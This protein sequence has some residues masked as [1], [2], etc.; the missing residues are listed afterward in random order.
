MNYKIEYDNVYDEL[1][2]RGYIDAATHEDEIKEMLATK[3]VP[4][5]IGFDATADSLTLGHFIQIMVMMRMQ[6]H[7]HIPVVLLGG[8]TTMVGDP[9]GRSDMR[10]VM[11]KEQID[12]NSQKF[13][14][15]FTRFLDF[16]DGKAYIENNSE[17]LLEINFI[18]FMRNVGV[19]FNVGEMIKKDAYKNR[20]DRGLSFFE[21]S[22]MLLQS[23]DF[24]VL[25]E[26]HDVNLQLGGSDQWANILGGIELIRKQKQ[27][28]AYGL[29]FCLL[30][31][32]AGEKMGKSMNGAIWLDQNK[33]SAYELFQYMRN[34][35]DRDVKKFLYLLTFLPSNEIEELTKHQDQRINKA[36]EVLAYEITRLVHGEIKANDALETARAI[37]TEGNL[38]KSMPTTEVKIEEF[39]ENK[40]LLN[41]LTFLGLT[42]SNGEARRLIDQGGIKLN[43]EKVTDPTLELTQDQIE[44]G[45]VI[46]KGKKVYHKVVFL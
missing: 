35:D 31:T 15:Q 4:F 28:Q 14:H 13:Y 23:Y 21:F 30:T 46:Q 18:D 22:Y 5:Y 37:F 6:A 1:V 32:A 33:T 38:D 44:H 19:H 11:S 43:D 39:E 27:E 2:A 24:L 10:M 29:T 17:W 12:E 36:K 9:T 20:L 41:M 42:K 26:R 8:G 3:K 34:V 45:L 16:S 7:G 25:N 40:G